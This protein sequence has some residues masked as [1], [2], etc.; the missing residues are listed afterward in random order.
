MLKVLSACS[1]V[2]A[3]Y[4]AWKKRGW[5]V[6]AFA[7]IEPFPCVVLHHHHSRGA[8]GKDHK[9]AAVMLGL[10][11]PEGERTYPSE[12]CRTCG[13]REATCGPQRLGPC[14]QAIQELEKL[15]ASL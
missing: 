12:R 7:E 15:E 5:K 1:G 3:A 6:V 11:K 4:A 10:Q 8:T 2:D 9:K 14:H 13:V